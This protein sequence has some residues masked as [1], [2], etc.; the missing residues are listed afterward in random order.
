MDFKLTQSKG[1]GQLSLPRANGTSPLD[2]SVLGKAPVSSNPSPPQSGG[3]TG[4]LDKKSFGS[5]SFSALPQRSVSF[6]KPLTGDQ[7]AKSGLEASSVSFPGSSLGSASKQFTNITGDLSLAGTIRGISGDAAYTDF[8]ARRLTPEAAQVAHGV[9]KADSPERLDYTF[10]RLVMVN[11]IEVMPVR[12]ML[13]HLKNSLPAYQPNLARL[14]NEEVKRVNEQLKSYGLMTDGVQLYNLTVKPLEEQG[15]MSSKPATC[16]AEDLQRILDFSLAALTRT[17]SA[18]D[19]GVQLSP[20]H[21]RERMAAA[22]S[23]PGINTFNQESVPIATESQLIRAPKPLTQGA[24]Q[25]GGYDIRQALQRVSISHANVLAVGAGQDNL[26]EANILSLQNGMQQ[27]TAFD[28]TLVSETENRQRLAGMLK[29]ESG[30]LQTLIPRAKSLL[31]SDNLD[32]TIGGDIGGVNRDLTTLNLR[33][34]RGPKGLRFLRQGIEIS[35]Q[36]FRSALVNGLNL[37]T[38]K[39]KGLESNLSASNQ[40]ATSLEQSSQQNSGKLE[41]DRTELRSNL[42][43]AAQGRAALMQDRQELMKI[44]NSEAWSQLSPQEQQNV[45]RM[46]KETDAALARLDRATQRGTEVDK[47]VTAQLNYSQQVRARSRETV[48]QAQALMREIQPMLDNSNQI[49]QKYRA[50]LDRERELEKASERLVKAANDLEAKLNLTPGPS[51]EK[52]NTEASQWLDQLQETA[53]LF[54]TL[55]KTEDNKQKIGQQNLERVAQTLRANLDYQQQKLQQLADGGR[56]KL[57]QALKASIS[58]VKA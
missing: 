32:S 40:R 33:V 34:E 4:P 58:A 14:S 28:Q 30:V 17:D 37:Q 43:A 45:E 50:M 48:Q 52:L 7:P 3:N 6:S 44:R 2:P 47:R 49:L 20:D 38:A 39:V 25:K 26:I 19:L 41:K 51:L 35:Q 16:S 36:D 18:A 55:Q 12:A 53:E 9:P 13:E 29:Q 24:F 56:E 42:G 15:G 23:I 22:T 27:Q 10:A 11:K 57:I 46:L 54:S 31:A 21:V 5:H 1:T 8:I